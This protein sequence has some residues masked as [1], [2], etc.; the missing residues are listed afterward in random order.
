MPEYPLDPEELKRRLG[1]MRDGYLARAPGKIAQIEL[2]W[3]RVRAAE[4]AG[5]KARDAARNEMVLAAHTMGGS[6][7]TLGCDALGVAAQELVSG[8]RTVF[9]RRQPLSDADCETVNKLIAA[10]GRS[11]D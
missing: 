8:L 7:P 11:L 1:K 6:A 5:E 4:T 10:L 2:L 3:E 9:G